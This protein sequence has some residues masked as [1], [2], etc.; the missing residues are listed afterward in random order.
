MIAASGDIETCP[1]W[2]A[3]GYWWD[4][5][6]KPSPFQWGVERCPCGKMFVVESRDGWNSWVRNTDTASFEDAAVFI[7]GW[8]D[9]Q[10]DEA[11]S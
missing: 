7:Q 1:E 10:V 4:G 3:A 5:E 8:F 11:L 9:S 6:W 2:C